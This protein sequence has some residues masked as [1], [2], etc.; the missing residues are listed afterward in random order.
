[1]KKKKLGSL[2]FEILLLATVLVVAL[3]FAHTRLGVQLENMT[4]D[5]RFQARADKDPPADSRVLLVAID[6]D[7]LA[8][9]H[10]WPWSR[11]VHTELMQQLISRSPSVVAF[12]LFFSEPS[13]DPAVDLNFGN[14]LVQMPGTITGVV[15][16]ALEHNKK[17]AADYVGNTRA[18]SN[19]EGDPKELVG[20]DTV[21]LPVKMIAESSHAGFVNCP[22]EA[23]GI[24]R[25]MPMVVRA[26]TRVFPSLVLQALLCLEGVETDAVEVVLGKYVRVKGTGKTWQIPIDEHGQMLINYRK[27]DTFKAFPYAGLV[28]ELK[29]H[30]GK[31]WPAD[32]PPVTGQVLF[33]GQTAEGLADIGPSPY[34]PLMPLVLTHANALSNILGGDYITVFDEKLA[35]AC[36]VLLT[37]ILLPLRRGSLWLAVLVP[38]AMIGAYILLAFH[39]FASFSLHVPLAWP[40]LGFFLGEGG[41]VLH[42]LVVELRAKSRIKGMFGSYLSPQVVERMIASGEEPKLGGEQLEITAFFSDI[43]SFSTFSEILPPEQLVMLMNDYLTEM[44]DILHESG[45][46]LD[47]FI[48]D[49]IV[50]MFGA[51]MPSEAHAYQACRAAILMQ[52]RQIELRRK[53]RQEGG[54]PNIVYEMQTRIGLNSGP[55]TIGNMGSRKRFNYTMMGDTVN[56]AARTESGAKSYGVYTMVTGKTKALAQ[57]HKDDLVYRFMERIVV[58]GRS[59]CTDAYELVGFKS[60]LS[61][62]TH[63]CL[64][65]FEEGIKRYLSQDWDGAKSF[66]QRAAELE[67]IM[68]YNP[69]LVLLGRCEALKNDPPPKDWDGV[70]VMKTK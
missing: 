20:H 61:S 30:Q 8:A 23:D 42:R 70:Y 1:M 69:S 5:W 44:T 2:R 56:L 3:G 33:I 27:S 51:P 21:L 38:L 11:S 43:A 47:K 26:G 9:Y 55:A 10:S 34:S 65:L 41:A 53:W 35:V 59:Q 15:A 16:Q 48:G 67:L 14:A 29:S 68:A 22:P 24:R 40:V 57:M 28:D 66:F 50:G 52:K 4:L 45:G 6:E 36:W 49:A 37:L 58:K 63:E 54:W 7:A 18:I 39:V 32:Y 25:R 62:Q 60:E 31:A 13:E 46:T 12:D 64:A 17:F 19:F